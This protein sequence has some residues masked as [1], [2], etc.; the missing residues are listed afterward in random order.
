LSE[1]PEWYYDPA[2][3]SAQNGG[4]NPREIPTT[5]ISHADFAKILMLG[6]SEQLWSPAY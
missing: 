3:N 1:I 4:L 6:L 2:T 5:R